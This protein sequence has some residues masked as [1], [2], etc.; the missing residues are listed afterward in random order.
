M[1]TLREVLTGDLDYNNSWT[2]LAKPINGELTLESKAKFENSQFVENYYGPNWG[3]V[4][5]NADYCD[6]FTNWSGISFSDE[7]A[8]EWKEE[9]AE[10]FLIER[11]EKIQDLAD[12]YS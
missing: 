6:A 4:A 8:D 2:I 12:Q 5:R 1:K 3:I 11:A 10:N 9:F 7:Q